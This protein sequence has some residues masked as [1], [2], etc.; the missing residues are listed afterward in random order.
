MHKKRHGNFL[1][2]TGEVHINNQGCKFTIIKCDHSDRCTVEFE[3]GYI[4]TN[5]K[6]GNIKLGKIK[7]PYYPSVYGVG[8]LGVGKHTSLK[9]Y[10]K[11]KSYCTWASMIQRCYG[12][13]D[14]K[15]QASYI[16]KT[17][18]EHWHNYQN[19]AEW[20]ESKYNPEYMEDWSLDKDILFK[21]NTI[22]SPETCC[23]VPRVLNN[24]I[25]N[26]VGKRGKYPLGVSRAGEKYQARF[27]K[28]EEVC[29]S[30]RFDTP[31][32]AFEFYKYHKQAWI[33]SVAADWKSLIQNQ[34]YCALSNWEIEITD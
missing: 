16:N 19:F 7:N 1:D 28:G 11:Q 25:L 5:V 12:R 34:V 20:F 23:L 4:V 21:G 17:V 9:N 10:K 24:I 13:I 31:K 29:R 26:R 32:E 27:K 22:Y 6:Y 18:I 2:R 30:K 33:K 14:N 8:Y 3:N 15:K